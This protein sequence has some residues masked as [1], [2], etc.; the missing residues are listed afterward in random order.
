MLEPRR[1]FTGDL[2]YQTEVVPAAA[3][4][5]GRIVL[6]ADVD[7]NGTDDL[8]TTNG[9]YRRGSSD[10]PFELVAGFGDSLVTPLGHTFDFDQDGGL[11]ILAKKGATDFEYSYMWFEVSGNELVERQLGVTHHDG[12]NVVFQA[13]DLDKDGGIDV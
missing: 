9:W 5:T 11:D 3:D 1:L 10:F 7:Q 12:G 4:L 13:S 6:V 8:V 2:S